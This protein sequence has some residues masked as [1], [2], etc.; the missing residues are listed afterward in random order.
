MLGSTAMAQQW[1][2]LRSASGLT[3]V[4]LQTSSGIDLISQGGGSAWVDICPAG[5]KISGVKGSWDVD[6]GLGLVSMA[7][8][9]GV[10]ISN[11]GAH[12]HRCFLMPK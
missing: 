3:Q 11:N 7:V 8:Q 5:L 9:C 1:T 4:A 2:S 10:S 12:T 6:S